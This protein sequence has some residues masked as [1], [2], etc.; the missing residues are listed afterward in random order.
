MRSEPTSRAPG[1][2]AGRGFTLVEMMIVTVVIGIIAAFAYPSYRQHV[3]RS[4]AVAATRALADARAAMEQF[5]LNGGSYVGGPCNTATTV[6]SFTVKC[7]A[8]PTISSYTISATGSG[9]TAG[10]VY[11]IDHHGRERSTALPADWGT[12]PASCWVLKPGRSC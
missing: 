7:V 1:P 2:P 8:A 3:Q 9:V 12:T 4:Q 11:T 6:E 10:F 5:Y